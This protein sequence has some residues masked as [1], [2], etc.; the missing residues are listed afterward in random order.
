VRVWFVWLATCGACRTMWVQHELSVSV[1]G[2]LVEHMSQQLTK[3]INILGPPYSYPPPSP[4]PPMETNN[5]LYPPGRIASA[6][7]SDQRR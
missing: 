7:P 6:D 1:S 4:P 3:T 5:D 2:S